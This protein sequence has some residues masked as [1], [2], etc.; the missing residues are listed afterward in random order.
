MNPKLAYRLS[1]AVLAVCLLALVSD[2]TIFLLHIAVAPK[3]KQA[4]DIVAFAWPLALV[5]F[6]VYQRKVQ[7][8]QG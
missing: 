7:R 6:G 3:V 8:P 4:L 2:L 5:F 1:A